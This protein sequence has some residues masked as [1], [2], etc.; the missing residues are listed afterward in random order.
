MNASLLTQATNHFNSELNRLSIEIASHHSIDW[1]GVYADIEQVR[2]EGL[3]RNESNQVAL[4]VSYVEHTREKHLVDT[5][6]PIVYTVEVDHSR[7]RY[8]NPARHFAIF[9]QQGE[10]VFPGH[11][12]SADRARALASFNAT[13]VVENTHTYLPS[14]ESLNVC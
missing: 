13:L 10:L 1:M 8:Y 2:V 6:N 11:P 5:H 9:T 12:D 7:T 3:I 4:L 14:E